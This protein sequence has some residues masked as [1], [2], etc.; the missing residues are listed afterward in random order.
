MLRNVLQLSSNY[1]IDENQNLMN[2]RDFNKFMKIENE[3]AKINQRFND[4]LAESTDK[5][6]IIRKNK[7]RGKQLEATVQKMKTNPVTFTGN[8]FD[9]KMQL[10]EYQKKM[11][12]YQTEMYSLKREVVVEVGLLEDAK[13]KFDYETLTTVMDV[14]IFENKME[15]NKRKKIN[16]KDEKWKKF[17][18]RVALLP[19]E[20]LRNIQS[21]FTYET[22]ADL[23]VHKYEPLKLFHSLNKYLLNKFIYHIYKKYYYSTTP[24]N[25]LKIKMTA[26]WKALY[27]NTIIEE[28]RWDIPP[29]KKL[30]SFIQYL[31]ILF[32]DY[33]RPQYCFE[34][35]REIIVLKKK[36][37][38]PLVVPFEFG[39]RST[40]AEVDLIAEDEDEPQV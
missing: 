10:K 31:F 32:I 15:E 19:D 12:R 36:L 8:I 37:D 38:Q 40:Q 28:R 13:K 34:L 16:A 6:K 3:K 5:N 26:I 4:F 24:Q 1:V 39:L 27:K 9:I 35:Y 23:L 11:D 2:K 14:E 33:G 21:Y 20:L 25:H 22:K 18:K 29:L 30:K 7:N 17:L